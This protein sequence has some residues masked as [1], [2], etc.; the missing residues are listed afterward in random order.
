RLTRPD[1]DGKDSWSFFFLEDDHRRVRR[2][3]E[4]ETLNRDFYHVSLFLWGGVGPSG[5]HAPGA[6]VRL[7]PWDFRSGSTSSDVHAVYARSPAVFPIILWPRTD[8]HS[9]AARSV[10]SHG[11]YASSRPPTRSMKGSRPKCP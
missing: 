1:P 5:L 4:P 9:S 8:T 11:K 6:D 3:V 7:P 2:A 10:R